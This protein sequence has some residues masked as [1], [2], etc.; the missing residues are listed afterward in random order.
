MNRFN[1]ILNTLLAPVK[2]ECAA[3][4]QLILVYQNPGLAESGNLDE[5][6]FQEGTMNKG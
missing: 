6:N 3:T 2:R 1:L 4:D 5:Y